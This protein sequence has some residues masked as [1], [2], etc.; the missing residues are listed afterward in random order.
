MIEI[1]KISNKE[2]V[3]ILTNMDEPLGR[4][5]GNNLEIIE[6]INALHGNMEKDVEELVLY[7]GS[8]MLLLA[9]IESDIEVGKRKVKEVIENGVAYNKFKELIERQGGDIS[10]IE[11]PEKFPKAN[12][13]YELFS[14]RDGCIE[15]INAEEVGKIS[16]LLGAG[17]INKDDNIDYSVG[18]ELNKKIGDKVSKGELLAR[19]Y[20]NDEEKGKIALERLSKEYKIVDYAVSMKQAI[21]K[22][23]Q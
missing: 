4:F 21:L 7:F 6:S 17:R 2:V 14:D 8:Y 13:I 23:L 10:Y 18:I 15:A 1:G 11:N 3:C 20:A 19:I 22:I 9:G 5:V 12:H 16:V